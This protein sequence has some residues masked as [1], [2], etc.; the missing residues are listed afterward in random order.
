M[1]GRDDVELAFRRHYA[2]QVSALSR[3]IGLRHL[4]LAEDAVQSALLKA[5]DVWSRN[6]PPE[7]PAAW[8]NKVARNHALER[9]R[10]GDRRGVLLAQNAEFV[11]TGPNLQPEATYSGEIAD[12]LLRMIFVCCDE[13]LPQSSQLVL[14]LK[15]LCGLSVREIAFLLFTEAETVQKRLQRARAK[16]GSKPD[17]FMENV[18]APDPAR[19]S[20]VRRTLYLLFTEGYHSNSPEACIR[21]DLC[22]EAIRLTTILAGH[23][24][25]D[26]P[27]TRALLALMHLHHARLPG[28][29]AGNGDLLLLEEQDRSAWDR[30]HIAEGLR[31]LEG[32][33]TGDKFSRYHAEAGIAA[34]HCLAPSFAETNWERIAD[35]YALLESQSPSMI[36]RLNRAVATVEYAGPDAGLALLEGLEPPTWLEGSYLWCAVLADIH[37]RCG[38]STEAQEYRLRAA[39]LAPN[40]HTRMMIERRLRGR[41]H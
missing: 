33:A 13:S 31:W 9:L 18:I 16:L 27:E 5:L 1:S 41:P 11:D 17:D 12:D 3:R 10:T 7:N 8:I 34:E 29:T 24:V 14:G 2:E 4:E 6:G 39:H 36:H 38:N 23:A 15:I 26:D 20:S 25:S 28:R 40:V 19:L 22:N 37:R 30:S 21:E 32:S 35:L